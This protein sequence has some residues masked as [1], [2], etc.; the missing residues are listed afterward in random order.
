MPFA[1]IE[2]IAGR[3]PAEKRAL[4]DA[5]HESLLE[6]LK[7]PARDN[8]QRIVEYAAEDYDRPPSCTA[9]R[10]YIEITM[11]PGRSVDAKRRLYQVLVDRLE[12]LGTP[13][14]D[15][16]IVLH[17]PAMVNFGIAGRPASEIDLGFN[18]HV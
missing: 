15:V 6:V 3:T 7:I 18:V 10:T 11:F 4:L 9:K 16:V 1:R 17:E 2:V 12:A 5:V 14:K 8:N 13:R